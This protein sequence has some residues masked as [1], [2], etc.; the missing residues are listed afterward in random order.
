LKAK[1]VQSIP[2]SFYELERNVGM[3]RNLL[4]TVLGD[5]HV[6]TIAYRDFWTSK[7]DTKHYVK[8]V[9]ILRSFIAKT[10]YSMLAILSIMPNY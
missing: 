10:Q 6:L 8:P 4:G 1:G 5:Q 3:F 9:H 7:F 2:L